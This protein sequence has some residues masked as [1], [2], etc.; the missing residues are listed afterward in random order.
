MPKLLIAIGP[1]RGDRPS[2]PRGPLERPDL[3]PPAPSPA[4][5]PKPTPFASARS[6]PGGDGFGQS[7]SREP[8]LPGE[9]VVQPNPNDNGETHEAAE[10][11]EGSGSAPFTQTQAGYTSGG[12]R[13]GGCSH[14]LQP[15][16][17]EYVQGPIDPDGSCPLHS[18]L[19]GAGGGGG[20]MEA[21]TPDSAMEEMTEPVD[22]QDEESMER[23]RGRYA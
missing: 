20:A 3:A 13:C 12:D 11:T 5:K 16:D 19:S 10:R 1:G 7:V 14:F 6:T 2:K 4:S 17:C 18:N 9:E 15:S 22:N 23:K 8:N 21:G